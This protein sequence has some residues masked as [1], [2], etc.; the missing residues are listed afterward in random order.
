MPRPHVAAL[1]HD[2][3]N[4]RVARRLT[5][6]GW[7]TRIVPHIGYGSTMT[8]R[9]LGRVVI[10]RG[11]SIGGNVWL[12]HGVPPGTR[13]TQAELVTLGFENGGGI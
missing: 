9:V 8:L 5:D 13:V 4:Q 11:S 7:G 6:R 1:V 2:A 3:W 12:T 10:G